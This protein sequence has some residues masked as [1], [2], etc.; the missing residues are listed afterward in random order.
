MEMTDVNLGSVP[1][2]LYTAYYGD[3]HREKKRVITARQTM[4]HLSELISWPVESFVDVGAGQGSLVEEIY[5]ADAAKK[6]VA[7]E[8]SASG[9]DAINQRALPNVIIKKFDGY[10][11]PCADKE[12]ELAAC[13]HVLE[14]VEHERVFLSEIKRISKRAVIEVP[15]EC[16][17]HLRRNIKT[18]RPFGHLNFYTVGTLTNLLETC[19]IKVLKL[20]VT[21]TTA[22]YEEH[23]NPRLGRIKHLI[24]SSAHKLA[25]NIA[26]SYLTFFATVLCDC[27][28]SS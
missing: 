13:V 16:N 4:Q 20:N 19:G 8:I 22:E 6:I 10:R 26:T 11:A 17:T 15:L 14:H 21:D 1:D 25:P 23:L 18:M 12:F 3:P 7:L 2:D 28:E 5:R 24:R 27:G 9:I